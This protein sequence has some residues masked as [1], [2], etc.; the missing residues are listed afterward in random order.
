MT[1]PWFKF[2][3]GEYL[4]DLKI[5]QLTAEERSCWVTLLCLANQSSGDGEIRFLSVDQLLVL[6]GVLEPLPGVLEKFEKL[7]MI[8][9]TNGLLTIN[10]W[11][12]RQYSEGYSRVKEFRKRKSNAEDNDR[13]YK[14]RIEENREDKN[15]PIPTYGE[16][17]KVKLSLEEYKKLIDKFGEKNTNLL[18]AELDTG[19]ASKGYKYKSHYATILNWARRKFAEHQNKSLKG[20]AIV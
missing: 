17:Q 1:N 9:I 20:K 18:I 2:Y 3:A 10:N 4:S 19:I 12:K 8:R 13:I 16:F 6:S 5:L 11:E 14:N 15:I 7:G